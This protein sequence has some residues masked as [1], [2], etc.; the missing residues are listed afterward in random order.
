[1]EQPASATT[2]QTLA[3][4]RLSQSRLDDARLAL[5]EGLS[6]WQDLP[7]E[8]PGVPDFAMRISLARLLMESELHDEALGVLER[9]IELDD[10]SVEAW[11]L[12]GWCHWLLSSQQ[13]GRERGEQEPDGT[14]LVAQQHR[15]AG[16]DW[17]RNCLR[18]YNLQGYEDERLKEHALELVEHLGKQLAG[19]D[20]EDLEE[21]E[22]VDEDEESVE[23]SQNP[24]DED[25][26]MDTG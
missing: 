22:W 5:R 19:A 1:M 3:S 12:G 20:P 24:V 21:D 18:L 7:P 9:L 25:D 15:S 16:R 10:E 6:R 26:E 4:I 11:Y 13:E 17:L 2:L 23:E 8:H 14:L